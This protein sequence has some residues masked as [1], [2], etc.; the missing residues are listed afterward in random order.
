MKKKPLWIHLYF[1]F[2]L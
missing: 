1:C 2:R